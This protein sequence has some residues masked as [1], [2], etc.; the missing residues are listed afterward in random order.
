MQNSFIDDLYQLKQWLT[1]KHHIPGRVRIKFSLSI[2]T[3]V[4]RFNQFKADIEQSPLIKS[5]RLNLTTG[6]LLVEYDEQIIPPYLIDELLMEDETQSL[7]A[8]QL[9]TEIVNEKHNVK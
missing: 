4:A 6:S 1:I 5:Y 3:K 8:L 7:K 2:L 9:L